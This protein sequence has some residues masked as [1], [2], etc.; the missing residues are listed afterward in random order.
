MKSIGVRNKSANNADTIPATASKP[1][2][3]V[4]VASD[5][6]KPANVAEMMTVDITMASP[7]VRKVL[8]IAML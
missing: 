5:D 2:F 7:S 4:C 3:F 8:R 6:M 1:Q